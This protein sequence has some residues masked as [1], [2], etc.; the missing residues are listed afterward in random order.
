[1]KI[2][3]CK[4][5]LAN[6]SYFM[7]KMDCIIKKLSLLLWEIVGKIYVLHHKS[8]FFQNTTHFFHKIFFVGQG[9][10]A[11]KNS[12]SETSGQK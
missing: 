5:T 9:P 11:L 6:K 8:P 3:L 4:W 12:I 1:M 2:L 10:F 7:E